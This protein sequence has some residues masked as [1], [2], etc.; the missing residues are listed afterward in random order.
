MLQRAVLA[1]ITD[2]SSLHA[3]GQ[4][5]DVVVNCT[6]LLA[7]KLGGV[8]DTSVIPARGQIVVVRNS[9][10]AMY[11]VSGTDDGADEVSY[12]MER[13]AGGGTILGGTYQKGSW[14]S[15]PNPNTA[16]AIMKR[17]IER[18]FFFP[19]LHLALHLALHPHGTSP[20]SSSLVLSSTCKQVTHVT[21]T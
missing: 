13:A 19:S 2:A 8:E 14:E 1:H 12:I 9:P 11:T 16:I 6:G 18:E 21:S 15:Q 5:A 4:R 17:A 7:S 10:G 3:S 20:V